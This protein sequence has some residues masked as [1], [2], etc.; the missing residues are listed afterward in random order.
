LVESVSRIGACG[1]LPALDSL[2]WMLGITS[3]YLSTTHATD[4][5][6]AFA[7]NPRFDV[8]YFAGSEEAEVCPDPNDR[9]GRLTSNFHGPVVFRPKHPAAKPGEPCGMGH[10]ALREAYMAHLRRCADDAEQAKRALAIGFARWPPL[11]RCTRSATV[12]TWKRRRLN[13][14]GAAIGQD[15]LPE[16]KA[17]ELRQH[18]LYFGPLRKDNFGT[19]MMA[20]SWGLQQV[21]SL[22]RGALRAHLVD[23]LASCTPQV[24][25][26]IFGRNFFRHLEANEQTKLLDRLGQSLNGAPPELPAWATPDR[27]EALTL[28]G[29]FR[30]AKMLLPN[31]ATLEAGVRQIVLR[32]SL[33]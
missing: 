14:H 6:A 7:G 30:A 26:V 17:H 31:I 10:A 22:V 28:P 12:P 20:E 5:F 13:E 1:D 15:I 4:I 23:A 32:E 25:K 33:A 9:Q 27:L 21:R 8:V 2:K 29:K 11:P 3:D 19:S 18:G 16:R 24:V